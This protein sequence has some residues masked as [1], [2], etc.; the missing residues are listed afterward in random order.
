MKLS[1]D[2]LVEYLRQGREIEFY[3][4]GKKYSFSNN[5]DGCYIT[6]YNNPIDQAFKTPD[7]LIEKG[8]IDGHSIKEIWDSVVIDII[9]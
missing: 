8:T 4:S 9:F 7:E 1:Y 3:F 5:N 2:T 6:E